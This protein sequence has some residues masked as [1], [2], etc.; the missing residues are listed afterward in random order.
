[1]ALLDIRDL[2]VS[3]TQYTGVFRQKSTQVIHGLDLSID[4]G[5]VA[6]VVGSSGSGKSLLAHAVVG[7]LPDNARMSGEIVYGGEPV[8]SRRL[9]T[10]RGKEI[11][12][13]PQ[14]VTY[15][16]PLMRVGS[17]VSGAIRGKAAAAA[18]RA[19]FKRYG[20]AERVERLYPFQLSGGMAR[21]VL[22]A[23]ATV[24]E[25]RL[26]I[27]DEPTPGMHERDV[28]EALNR[29]REL[30]DKGCAVLCITHDIESALAIAD[31]VAV[32]YAGTIVEIAPAEEFSGG[33]E[34]LRHPYSR[35]L[36]QA[37]PQNG[38]VPLAG[39]Q[40]RPDALPPGCLFAPR[41]ASASPECSGARPPMR[42]L[43]GGIVRCIH[44]D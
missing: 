4:A 36:W 20:L 11:A 30:A 38:F 7:I 37:L 39:S 29:L 9:R 43:R 44:A 21:R 24:S 23:T 13:V 15:L 40:P 12:F 3:F 27:A 10:L 1:M 32:L 22:V 25:P 42:E 19:I 26:I 33:G 6:V 34:R 31:K 2:C 14:S 28:K 16:D 8:D 17:Q 5:E 35:A 18:R 41:C